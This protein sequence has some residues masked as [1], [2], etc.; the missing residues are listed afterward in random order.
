MFI[1]Y[2][3][4]VADACRGVFS[5]TIAFPLHIFNRLLHLR[6]PPVSPFRPSPTIV[7]LAIS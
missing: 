4:E 5:S 3:K 6:L 1:G 2:E 7:A